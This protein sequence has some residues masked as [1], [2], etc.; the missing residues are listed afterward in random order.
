MPKSLTINNDPKYEPTLFWLEAIK[1]LAR[2]RLP[3]FYVSCGEKIG[4]LCPIGLELLAFWGIFSGSNCTRVT[5][6]AIHFEYT[7]FHV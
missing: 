3:A 5:V 6:P 2:R 4:T 7:V 1:M